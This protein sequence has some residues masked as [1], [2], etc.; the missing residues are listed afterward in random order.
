MSDTDACKS[1]D[2]GATTTSTVQVIRAPAGD[3]T[4][5]W[6]PR[7]ALTSTPIASTADTSRT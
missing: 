7:T 3:T 6:V 2:H 5:P 4:R 1:A